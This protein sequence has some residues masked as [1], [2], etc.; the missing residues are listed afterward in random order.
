MERSSEII[1]PSKRPIIE[2]GNKGNVNTRPEGA[3]PVATAKPE[4][5]PTSGTGN[6]STQ[7]SSQD[8]AQGSP[9]QS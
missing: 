3:K 8:T 1:N 2:S 5:R 7:G 9:Q 4:C 6:G